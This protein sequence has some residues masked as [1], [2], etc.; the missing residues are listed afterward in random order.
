MARQVRRRGGVPVLLPGLALRGID[1]AA[2]RSAMAD[3]L[4]DQ[5]VIFTSP[6][7]VRFAARLHA[8][9]TRATVL[10]VGQGTLR[11]LH[12]QGVTDAIAPMERQDSEGLLGLPVWSQW[13]A[14][15]IALIDAPGGRGLLREQLAGRGMLREVQVYRRVTPRLRPSHWEQVVALPA[16]SCLL[17]SSAEALLNLRTLAPLPAWTS[18]S[19]CT[20]V[21]SSRRLADV[22]SEAGFASIRLARSAGAG[23]LL[24]AVAG[25]GVQES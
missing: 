1:D 9:R 24:D 17:L 6:A 11:A 23:A 2:T 15:R 4:H 8:L 5:V 19:A 22:A 16:R 18:L 21:V 3:A 14:P 13:Q 7:A 20:A 25:A 12:R 10:A